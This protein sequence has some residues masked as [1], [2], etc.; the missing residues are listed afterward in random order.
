[1]ELEETQGAQQ[2]RQVARTADDRRVQKTE[3]ALKRALTT[4]LREKDIASIST[5]ELCKLAGVGRNT[6]YAHYGSPIDLLEA[7][8]AQ[9]R[10]RFLEEVEESPGDI[11]HWL[12]DMYRVAREE[13]DLILALFAHEDT[14][15]FFFENI[16]AVYFTLRPQAKETDYDRIDPYGAVYAFCTGGAMWMVQWWLES[17]SDMSPETLARFVYSASQYAIN[18]LLKDAKR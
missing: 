18:G 3:A 11:L 4:L 5:T 6:F 12:T 10:R 1:M 16:D 13:K 7:L 8:K 17:D 15:K 2:P 14:A 9:L